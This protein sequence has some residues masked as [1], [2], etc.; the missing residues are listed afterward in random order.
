MFFMEGVIP[1]PNRSNMLYPCEG[2]RDSA[3]HFSTRGRTVRT[4]LRICAEERGREGGPIGG[5]RARTRARPRTR[6]QG[7][8]SA[9]KYPKHSHSN[10]LTPETQSIQ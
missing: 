8:G 5:A 6:V 9:R 4:G 2:L 10:A 3:R 7:P 1:Q